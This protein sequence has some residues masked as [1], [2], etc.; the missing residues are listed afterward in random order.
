MGKHCADRLPRAKGA[1]LAALQ[2]VV[3]EVVDD[4]EE[5]DGHGRLDQEERQGEA[6]KRHHEARAQGRRG[7][8]VGVDL[9][10][11]PREALKRAGQ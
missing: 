11:P 7:D 6:A 2:A 10:L 8:V 5:E 4:F 9:V 3:L 1:H